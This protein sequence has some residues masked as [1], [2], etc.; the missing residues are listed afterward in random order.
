MNF[1][2]KFFISAKDRIEDFFLGTKE[3]ICEGFSYIK[4]DLQS[5]D[6]TRILESLLM[7]GGVCAVFVGAIA[8]ISFMIVEPI[9]TFTVIITLIIA[10][11]LIILFAYSIA[12]LFRSVRELIKEIRYLI[13]RKR[14]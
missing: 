6:L 13:W 8:I 7:L 3:I 4:E 11:C 5:D 14:K 1:I 12:Y 9:E 10:T 2:R